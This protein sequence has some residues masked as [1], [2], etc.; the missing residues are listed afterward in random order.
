MRVRAH[1]LEGLKA[2]VKPEGS[3]SVFL[4]GT[5]DETTYAALPRSFQRF[6]VAVFNAHEAE[7]WPALRHVHAIREWGFPATAWLVLTVPASAREPLYVRG[8]HARE[9]AAELRSA[10]SRIILMDDASMAKLRGCLRDDH[11]LSNDEE[12]RRAGSKEL[13]RDTRIRYIS[14]DDESET[15]SSSAGHIP[16]KT[17]RKVKDRSK[18]AGANTAAD[19]RSR[20]SSR[21]PLPS[22]NSRSSFSTPSRRG[23]VSSI[24]SIADEATTW[25][26]SADASRL[27]EIKPDDEETEETPDVPE[28]KDE[29]EGKAEEASADAS[30]KEEVEAAPPKQAVPQRSGWLKWLYG[31]YAGRAESPESTPKSAPFTGRCHSFNL[32]KMGLDDEAI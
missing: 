30:A 6:V 15:K 12:R 27:Q 11:S 4:M 2:L 26:R 1:L 23:S 3:V 10:R 5:F 9:G 24:G 29:G 7:D 21:G 25:R 28:E 32:K 19:W 14:D 18:A 17:R 13:M 16:K 31:E 8:A 22:R 20:S